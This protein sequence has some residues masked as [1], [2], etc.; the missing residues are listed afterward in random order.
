MKTRKLHTEAVVGKKKHGGHIDPPCQEKKTWMV[1]TP[2]RA[3]SASSDIFVVPRGGG[4]GSG[5]S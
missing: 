3:F 1:L 4:R 5:G 2:S